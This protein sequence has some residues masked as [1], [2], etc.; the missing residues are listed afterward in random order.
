[1]KAGFRLVARECS[2]KAAKPRVVQ[3]S[4]SLPKSLSSSLVLA[5]HVHANSC[6]S[7]TFQVEVGERRARRDVM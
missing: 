7:E 6:A 1:M 2:T 3:A 5:V 4:I